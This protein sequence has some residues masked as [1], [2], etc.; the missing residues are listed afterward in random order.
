MHIGKTVWAPY[1]NTGFRCGTIL[2]E[3]I[4]EKWLYVKVD[5]VDD[6]EFEMDRQRLI[7][8]RGKDC[9]SD[10]RRIDKVKIFDKDKMIEK[11]NKL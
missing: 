1:G 4:C 5:W 3:Q 8:L 11:I 6:H 2:E 9:R 7:D 10:W